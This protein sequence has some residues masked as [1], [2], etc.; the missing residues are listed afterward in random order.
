MTDES[1]PFESDPDGPLWDELGRLPDPSAPV[2]AR[3]RLMKAVT[4]ELGASTPASTLRRLVASIA[5]LAVGASGGALWAGGS[6][7][8]GQSDAAAPPSDGSPTWMLLVRDRADDPLR[9]ARLTVEMG[10]WAAER[11]AEGA[12][13]DGRKLVVGDRVWVGLDAEEAR[14]LPVSGFFMIRAEDAVE[15]REVAATLPHVAE[16]G[17]VEVVRVDARTEDGGTP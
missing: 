5:L 8:S 14:R 2:G 15:A 7:G 12:L 13:V 17:G 11:Q 1:T 16:G 6:P 10:E 3:A 4:A 9:D